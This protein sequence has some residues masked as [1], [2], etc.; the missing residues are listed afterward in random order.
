M[1]SGSASENVAPNDVAEARRQHSRMQYFW[2]GFDQPDEAAIDPPCLVG[3]LGY[4]L[5]LSH[6]ARPIG[7]INTKMSG[8]HTSLS[9]G[10][11]ATCTAE[12]TVNIWLGD[13]FCD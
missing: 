12:L 2:K 4:L 6:A 11:A 8:K 1:G 10:E 9:A 3:T 13:T 5:D 7:E